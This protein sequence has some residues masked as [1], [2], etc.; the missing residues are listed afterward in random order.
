[1]SLSAEPAKQEPAVDAAVRV[2]LECAHF[3]G[4]T[5]VQLAFFEFIAADSCVSE[6]RHLDPVGIAA[7]D[8]KN[9]RFVLT[10]A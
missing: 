6:D 2:E 7:S 4:S 8:N 3:G 9:R 1:V 10:A 5:D